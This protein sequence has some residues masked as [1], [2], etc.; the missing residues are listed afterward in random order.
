MKPRCENCIILEQKVAR[1]EIRLA[2]LERQLMLNSK[3]SS[4]PPSTDGLGKAPVRTLSLR[5]A[6]GRKTGGQLGHQGTTLLQVGNPDEIIEHRQAVCECCGGSLEDC[7]I[8][9]I[10]QRQVFDIGL[11]KKQVVQ[12]NALIVKCR[13]CG[14]RNKSPFPKDIKGQVQYGPKFEAVV[15]YLSSQQLIPENR[16][17]EISREIFDMPV[18]QGTLARIHKGSAAKL[19]PNGEAVLAA[20]KSAPVKHLDESGIRVNGKLHWLHVISS[21]N[22]THYRTTPNRGHLLQ[23]ITGV[24]VHDY[25]K[26]YFNLAKVTH[27]L[28]NAHILRELKSLVEIE[29]EPWA[30]DMQTLLKGLCHIAKQPNAPP[31]MVEQAVKIYDGIVAQGLSYHQ[32]MPPLNPK[33]KALGKKRLGHNLLLRLANHKNDVLRFLVVPEI[34]FTNN[35]A[36]QD[37]RMIKVKQKISGCFRTIKGVQNFLVIRGFLSTA[38]KQNQNPL[39]A[40]IAALG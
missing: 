4:K 40:L 13:R 3:N 29:K 32:A 12:H 17:Q 21:N 1:L 30:S 18:S 24:V 19:A 16:L 5:E 28:C 11:P 9:N 6:S 15:T 23:N 35:Q 7:E 14:R 31:D 36:E 26:P 2:E 8:V 39:H 38:R 33:R 27:A 20:L 25:W 10:E 37:I 34:P 22:Q